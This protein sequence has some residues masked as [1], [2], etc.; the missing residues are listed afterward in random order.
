MC[1]LIPYLRRVDKQGGIG[2]HGSDAIAYYVEHPL[3]RYWQRVLQ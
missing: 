1:T 2:R 3:C